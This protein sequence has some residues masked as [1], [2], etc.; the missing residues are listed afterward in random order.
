MQAFRRRSSTTTCTATTSTPGAA[1]R[2]LDWG[3]ACVSHPLLTSFVTFAHLGELGLAPDDPW[4]ARLRDAYLDPRGDFA[5]ARRAYALAR[6]L[7]PLAHAF[8]ELRTIGRVP[9]WVLPQLTA[10]L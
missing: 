9:D 3:D 5:G 2:I 6:S 10:T 4:A 8:K 1:P 7:G